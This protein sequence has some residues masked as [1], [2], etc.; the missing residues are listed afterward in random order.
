LPNSWVRT[1]AEPN[2]TLQEIATVVR[3]KN[4]GPFEICIDVLFPDDASYQAA[5]ESVALSSEAFG[6]LYNLPPGDCAVVWFP[7]ARALKCTMPRKITA[8]DPTDIDV[9]GAQHY[10]RMMTVAI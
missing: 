6:R 5:R 3:S 7:A 4:A 2:T 10:R 9:Y 8:G 1:V